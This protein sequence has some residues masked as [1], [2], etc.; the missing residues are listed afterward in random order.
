ME[1][2]TLISIWVVVTTTV[3]VLAYMRMSMGM[4]DV[5]RVHLTGSQPAID[6]SEAKLIDRI[7]VI[8]RF[9]IPL[10]V[11]SAVLALAIFIVWA[12]GEAGPG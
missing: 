2:S 6:V 12:I 3:V 9:G 8:D 4:H 7:R 11:I 1:L 10:T 5:M